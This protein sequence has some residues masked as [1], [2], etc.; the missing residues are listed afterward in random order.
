MDINE[1]TIRL[2]NERQLLSAELKSLLRP[3]VE[4]KKIVDLME[5]LKTCLAEAKAKKVAK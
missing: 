1:E 2:V 3:P 4:E 5:A